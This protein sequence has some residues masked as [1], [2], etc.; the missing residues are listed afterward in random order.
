MS[1]EKQEWG[2]AM[3]RILMGMGATLLSWCLC[4]W[5]CA[6]V[7]A[8]PAG[9]VYEMVSPVYKG[10][11]G[12]V[13][14]SA[15]IAPDGESVSY[16]SLGGFA[17]ILAG[18]G[19]G[20]NAYLAS[21]TTAGWS[22]VGLQPPFG[23]P[24]DFSSTME[25]SLGNGTPA[26]N[27]G[28][29][30]NTGTVD[31]I[32]LHRNGAANTAASWEPVASLTRS[33]EEPLQAIVEGAS[34]DLC[35]IFVG[36]TDGAL[37][38]V[39]SQ[40][41]G[42]SYEV[43]RGC[44]SERPSVRLIALNNA[45]KEEVLNLSGCKS[46]MEL[47]VGPVLTNQGAG[48]E[49]KFNAI[50]AEG[51]EVFFSSIVEKKGA[52]SCGSSADVQLFVRLNGQRTVEVSKPL[53]E[54]CLEVPC[55]P[56]TTKRASAYF[57]GA[58]EDGSRVFFTTTAPLT[59]DAEDQSSNLFMAS[60]GCAQ[61]A[62]GC[63]LAQEQVT[64][65]TQVS[66]DTIGG[67]GAEVQGVVRVAP[68]GSRVYFVARGVLS[69]GVNAEGGAPLEG[70]DNLYVYDSERQRMSFIADLCS[71]PRFS[72]VVRDPQC[73]RDLEANNGTRTDARLWGALPEAQSAG[74]HA[75]FLVFSS[76]AQLVASDIDNAKDIYRY[77]SETGSLERVSVGED[78]Y[79]GEGNGE[80]SAAE[81]SG[82]DATIRV[83]HVGGDAHVFEQQELRTRAITADGSTIVFLSN[84]ALSP[85][86]T[87]GL[88][89]VYE[90]HEGSVSLISSGNADQPDR[91]AVIT[92]SGRDL[93]FTTS[94]GLVAQDRDGA[95]DIYD[96]R[97]D[98]GFPAA[99]AA[100]EPC[101]SDGCPG[102]LS[103]P[104]PLL[105]PGSVA[106]APGEN[107]SAPV[108]ATPKKLTLAQELARALKACTKK[109]KS[110][111]AACR[112]S[113]RKK[114][115]KAAKSAGGGRG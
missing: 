71:G 97:V 57:K 2:G 12:V 108:K 115:A 18:A 89:N 39:A 32:L 72:G 46:E 50:A 30:Q 35:H 24:V 85:Q 62:P 4:C 63:Q 19:T 55:R 60:I 67:Q 9:R 110:K 11:Y 77:D 41:S 61:G 23:S 74:E 65:L 45:E 17:G 102:P 8:L 56:G 27:A 93:F 25:Y 42:Q 99:P 103:N 6:V 29:Q 5:V 80:D 69:E 49:S 101:V 33:D 59:G 105:V 48:E 22:T 26:A 76:Y 52:V 88:T 3:G 51:R 34:G 86:A 7:F 90:W 75:R 15:S 28:R 1:V 47:G 64:S 91:D 84:G 104:A 36:H 14:E 95:L 82:A 87:N 68:D 92:P 40:T 107:L 37:L 98:G 13:G 10:G 106:Q 79:A 83:G 100:E 58:S 54:A 94:Q 96:A 66:H 53:G 78:G 81:P 38:S 16:N 114:Y 111:R 73:P 112:R 70:A 113:A 20:A 109:S 44:G 21:R 31:E 43:T